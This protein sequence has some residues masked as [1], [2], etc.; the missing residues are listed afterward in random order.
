MRPELYTVAQLLA[1]FIRTG[2]GP[3]EAMRGTIRRG[4]GPV[5]EELGEAMRWIAGGMGEAEALERLAEDTAEPAAA[6][7]YRLL[8]AGVEAGSDLGAALLTTSDDLR[9]QR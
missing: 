6:R 3:I 4:T 7:L 9:S 2:H 5:V 1:M 8:G